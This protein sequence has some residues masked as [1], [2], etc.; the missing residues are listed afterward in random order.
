MPEPRVPIWLN[1]RSIALSLTVEA[2]A[3]GGAAVVLGKLQVLVPAVAVSHAPPGSLLHDRTELLLDSFRN[4]V[5]PTPAG[6]AAKSLSVSSLRRG[7]TSS[8]ERSVFTSLM[9]QLMS[10][11]MPPGDMTPPCLDVHCR[12]PP[13]RESVAEMAVGH[14]EGVPLCPAGSPH[15]SPG[16]RPRHPSPG[17]A[18][19]CRK[20]G[21]APASPACRR[22]AAPTPYPICA[23][24]RQDPSFDMAHSPCQKD[25][26]ARG[27]YYRQ[28][29][30]G[31]RMRQEL[32]THG[33]ENTI[34]GRWDPMLPMPPATL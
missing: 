4:P 8:I 22:R 19:R 18:S 24:A 12:D 17:S 15:S 7:R 30:R 10:K 2:S 3:P 26:R 29:E 21:R 13:Y 28:R 31:I 6:T 1:P 27:G 33:W 32:S 23:A 11:P 5:L 16:R 20:S 14:A 9:P 34:R 25:S